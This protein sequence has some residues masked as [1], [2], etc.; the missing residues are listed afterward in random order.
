MKRTAVRT[1]LT[2]IAS[3]VIA[4]GCVTDQE[5]LAEHSG[6]ALKFAEVQARIDL[7]C[8]R[9]SGT[10]VSERIAQRMRW[11]GREELAEYSI[12][13]AGCGKNA[14]YDIKCLSGSVCSK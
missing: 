4:S 1:P 3:M 10:I 8:D 13:V 2:A 7:D 14:T 5:F 9:V 6:A 12:K 11:V